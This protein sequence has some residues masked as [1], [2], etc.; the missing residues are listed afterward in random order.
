[1]DTDQLKA[2]FIPQRINPVENFPKYQSKLNSIL[3]G[4]EAEDASVTSTNLSGQDSLILSDPD[5][6][7]I[8]SDNEVEKDTRE[9]SSPTGAKANIP[10]PDAIE[11]LMRKLDTRKKSS[12][13]QLSDQESSDEW[14]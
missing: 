5:A 2:A 1:M 7:S 6:N 8:T 14:E 9:T 13:P 4:N 12:L 3:S 10:E 11:S